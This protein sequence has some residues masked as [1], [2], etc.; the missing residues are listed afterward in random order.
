MKCKQGS[1]QDGLSRLVNINADGVLIRTRDF[2][3]CQLTVEQSGWHEVAL[4]CGHTLLQ[5]RAAAAQMDEC[6]GPLR[7]LGDGNPVLPFE[8]RTRHHMTNRSAQY[9]S[10]PCQPWPSVIIGQGNTG[11]HFRDTFGGMKCVAFREGK[12]QLLGQCCA[13]G[14]LATAG[15]AH[16][17]NG[18]R[19]P[20]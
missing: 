15:N 2:E 4:A 13:K 8:R 9:V 17:N 11:G 18:V 20:R 6:H 12:T 7:G 1:V 19:E 16:D 3:Y 5:N 10:N 14:G